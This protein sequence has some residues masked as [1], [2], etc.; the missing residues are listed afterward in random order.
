VLSWV[1]DTGKG[2]PEDELQKI[3][4][5][6][7]QIEPHTTRTYGGMGIGLSIA[8]GLVEA[9]CGTIW[10]E[11]PGLGKGSTFKV[12]LPFLSTTALEMMKHK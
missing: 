9:H 12:L 4:Q 8:K 1:Q 10:A 2:I 11:S 3:F 6:F 7:Y 5:E